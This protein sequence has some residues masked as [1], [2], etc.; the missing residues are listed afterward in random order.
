MIST[1]KIYPI[2][3]RNLPSQ[4]EKECLKTPSS[5]IH[6]ISIEHKE[7]IIG[8][9]TG[10]PQQKNDIMKLAMNVPNDDDDTGI[11]GATINGDAI[12]LLVKDF[13]SREYETIEHLNRE[14]GGEPRGA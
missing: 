14:D 10:V 12:G 11:S 4:Q 3:H 2:R 6:I 1:Q 13:G 5:S 7:A 9:K 8:R